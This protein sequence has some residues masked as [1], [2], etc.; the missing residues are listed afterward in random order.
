MGGLGE[1]GEERMER[2]GD[3]LF[4]VDGLQVELQVGVY[5]FRRALGINGLND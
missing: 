4:V 5:F 2:E 1:E 3:E